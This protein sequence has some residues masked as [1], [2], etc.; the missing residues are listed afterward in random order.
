MSWSTFALDTSLKICL[1]RGKKKKKAASAGPQSLQSRDQ[2]HRE[3]KGRGDCPTGARGTGDCAR[4]PSTTESPRRVSGRELGSPAKSPLVPAEARAAGGGCGVAR[5][6]SPPASG[7][8]LLPEPSVAAW[9]LR[10]STT[11]GQEWCP[12][13][14]LARVPGLTTMLRLARWT[15]VGT[16]SFQPPTLSGALPPVLE[17]LGTRAGAG[18]PSYLPREVTI[19]TQPGR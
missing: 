15:P 5:W 14:S 4:S 8:P 1:G 9:G 17:R 12:Q 6:G 13:S 2:R 7:R 16:P 3:V 10:S 18:A 19:R 11:P